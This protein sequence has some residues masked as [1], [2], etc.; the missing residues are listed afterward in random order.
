MAIYNNKDIKVYRQYMGCLPAGEADSSSSSGIMAWGGQA[1]SLSVQ[2][3]CGE[4]KSRCDQAVDS[5]RREIAKGTAGH[6][7]RWLGGVA[8][9]S[10]LEVAILDDRVRAAD[11]LL[12]LLAL[13]LNL[14]RRLAAWDREPVTREHGVLFGL[15][16]T[17][18]SGFAQDRAALERV[19]VELAV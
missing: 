18:A 17:A 7:H 14:K 13:H 19:R 11:L 15:P 3:Y 1:A 10:I 16:A 4:N 9:E 6:H 5:E 12:Q 8:E 2:V